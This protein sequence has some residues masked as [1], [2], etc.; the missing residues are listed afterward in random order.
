MDLAIAETV[1]TN[2]AIPTRKKVGPSGPNGPKVTKK[3]PTGQQPET[4]YKF[5]GGKLSKITRRKSHEITTKSK[6]FF[7]ICNKRVQLSTRS[8]PLQ[9][10]I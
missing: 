6:R 7:C 1:M 9:P 4:R 5:Q 10:M 3:N 2:C 8:V